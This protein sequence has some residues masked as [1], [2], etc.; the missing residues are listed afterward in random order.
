MLYSILLFAFAGAAGTLARI[1][2]GRTLQAWAGT[3]FP[4]GTLAV[5]L[6]GS[7]LFGLFMGL[8]EGRITL[9]PE[10]RNLFTLGFLGAFTTF[11]TFSHE[12]AQLFKQGHGG[13][14]LAN[15]G[16]NNFLALCLVWLG[17]KWAQAL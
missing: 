7:F 11:A 12:T 2:L 17:W 1:G 15:I 8:G 3:G 13:L 10:A 6:L 16:A 5:N 14:A 9:S 4:L